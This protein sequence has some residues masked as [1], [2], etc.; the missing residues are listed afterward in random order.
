MENLIAGLVTVTSGD[1]L[2]YLVAGSLLGMV[3]GIIPGLST[4]VILSVILIFAFKINVT[5][6]LCLFLGANCGGYYSASVS[7][8][9]MNT[10]AH[11]EAMPIT[12]DGYPMARS[13]SPA[14]ALGL[15]AG[16]TCVGGFIGC[17]VLVAFLPL[18]DSLSD[19]SPTRRTTRPSSSLRCFWSVRSARIP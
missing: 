7:A 15:S 5:N 14:R 19:V 3:L 11:P 1:A 8:I 16:S 6:A 10:P 4:V 9:L 12:F 13:G 17:A 18:M 2:I